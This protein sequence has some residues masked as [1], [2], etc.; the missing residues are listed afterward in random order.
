MT[1]T[2]NQLF[3]SSYGVPSQFLAEIDGDK[4]INIKLNRPQYVANLKRRQVQI[5]SDEKRFT[6]QK[7]QI[8]ELIKKKSQLDA[9]TAKLRADFDV[10]QKAL[11]GGQTED[12]D[13]LMKSTDDLQKMKLS[14]AEL[15]RKRDEVEKKLSW[16]KEKSAR[17]EGDIGGE[18]VY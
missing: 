18:N 12:F 4:V 8:D 1:R 7:V 3:I 14:L 15:E 13:E 5:D 10:A 2:K 6:A 9:V 16:L 17:I 11:D